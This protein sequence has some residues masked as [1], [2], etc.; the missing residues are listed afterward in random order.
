MKNTIL[1]LVLILVTSKFNYAQLSATYPCYAVSE[2]SPSTTKPNVLFEY[3]SN[4]AIWKKIGI[5][6]GTSIEAIAIDP[7]SEIIYATD[8]GVFGTIDANTAL[9]TAIGDIGS[10]GNTFYLDDVDGLTYDS[11]NHLMYATYK[12]SGQGPHSNDMLFIIDV[13]I[14]SIVRGGMTSLVTDK[15]VDFVFV[16]KVFNSIINIDLYDVDDLAYNSNTSQLFA[17]HNQSSLDSIYNPSTI[18]QLNPQTGEVIDVILDIP[19][20]DLESLGFNYLG[21]LYATTGNSGLIQ[22]T[23]NSLVLIDLVEKKTTVIN[24]IDPTGVEEDFESFDCFKA[25]NNLIL[26]PIIQTQFQSF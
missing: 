23:K 26:K 17:L 24:V 11:T 7:V 18:T 5:T 9:F 14:G 20:D 13:S 4:T 16:P 3:N 21:E 8:G 1:I 22:E 25:T 10:T 12:I 15:A 2:N 19:I 6:G